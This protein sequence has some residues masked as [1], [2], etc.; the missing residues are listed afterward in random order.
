[1]N[2]PS[3]IDFPFLNALIRELR[4]DLCARFPIENSPGWWRWLSW[5]VVT[6]KDE[7]GALVENADFRALLAQP[8][9]AGVS[10][11]QWLIFMARPDVQ[12]VYPV[13][14]KRHEYLRWF[15]HHGVQ[16]H[17]LWPLLTEAEECLLRSKNL[18]PDAVSVRT[19]PPTPTPDR[20]FG[21]N[22][23]GYV[24][25]QLGIG[26]DLRMAARALLAAD[27]PIALIDF[28]P[29]KEI[30]QNDHSMDEYVREEGEYAF[31][32]FCLT[33]LEHGRFYAE[34]GTRQIAGRT[35]IGYWPWELGQWPKPWEPL[36]RLVDE[37]WV[38]TQHIHDALAPVSPVPVR[39]MPMAVELGPIST[40]HRTD[41]NL[42]ADAVLFC[43]SFDLNSSIH[44]KNPHACIDAFLQAFPRAAPQAFPPDRV[45]LVIKCHRPA[46][47]HRIWERLKALAREDSRIHIIEQT[48]PRPDLL[49]LYACCDC[50]LSLHRAE[51]FGRGIAEA[52]QL[53]LHVITTGYSG[54][55]DFCHPPQVDLVPY[56]L[57][58]IR[59]GYY[60]Y[61]E[62]QVWAEPDVAEAARLMRRFFENPVPHRDQRH[63]AW[64]QFSPRTVGLRYR[65]RLLHLFH[66]HARNA[67]PPLHRCHTTA[68][69]SSN[70]PTPFSLEDLA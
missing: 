34:R 6:G 10:L 66:Q 65:E 14:T 40:M 53:G 48:L 12:K 59:K 50:Y 15:Y 58:R 19:T 64:Q 62:G 36:T 56:R 52:L 23:I 22:L 28:P 8:T 33:A 2:S 26:E 45:G 57:V 11:L 38:S 61:G 27:V 46:K 31:N 20:R 51:G 29:G 16:E 4:K 32:I 41:F 54:N 7:Y 37:V 30:P 70:H 25:G 42:P 21:V 3:V 43:F 55:L 69:V 13:T 63:G 17:G 35:N 44:R 49:A 9:A 67:A 68:C 5:L 1:M 47:K 39:I 18:W 24:H 60:P